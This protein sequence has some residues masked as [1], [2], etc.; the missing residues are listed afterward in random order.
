[1]PECVAGTNP[2]RYPRNY[3]RFPPLEL[4]HR[5]RL[6]LKVLAE[7]EYEIVAVMDGEV[8]PAEAF[9]TE[10]P[11]DT[12]ATRAGLIGMLQHVATNGFQGV[13]SKWSHEANK[14][15]QVYEFIKGP[16]RLFYFKGKGKQIAVCT[17][18]VRK[19]GDKADAGAVA[20]A[21]GMRQAYMKAVEENTLEIVSD[22]ED[23]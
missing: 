6:K 16:L 5:L 14:Q 17:G 12:A 2:H 13:P 10:G 22:E 23:Q 21:A 7:A 20:T 1:M 18:G 15:E 8:C 4:T 19:K 11:A 3:P 9:L